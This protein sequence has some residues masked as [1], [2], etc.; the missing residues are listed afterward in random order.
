M[1]DITPGTH[2]MVITEEWNS[3]TGVVGIVSN[4]PRTGESYPVMVHDNSEAD[5]YSPEALVPVI[6][7]TPNYFAV[8]HDGDIDRI[9][10]EKL[11]EVR[12]Y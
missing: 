9:D 3:D 7:G 6:A 5:W 10:Y 2:V 8:Y 12:V 1:A 4:E 11:E